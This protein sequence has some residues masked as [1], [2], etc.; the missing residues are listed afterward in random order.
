MREVNHRSKNMLAVVQAIARRTVATNPGEFI[1]RFGE[2]VRALAASQ[3][4]L[5]ESGWRG[6]DLHELVVSQ[7]S[8]LKDLVD[9]R[10]ELRGQPLQISASS[11]Q[12][13]GMAVHE[14][15]TNAVKYGALSNASGRI[16]VCWCLE[17]GGGAG[18]RFVMS[19]RESGGPVVAESPER[20]GFGST[21]LCQVARESLDAEVKLDFAPS[22]LV[23]RLECAAAEAIGTK[24]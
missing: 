5:I 12:V 2:R 17:P 15:A 8:H 18:E 4:L 24:D 20:R 3:D 14:L 11:A 10:I 6:V 22:G 7:L 19:W 13:I 9:S 1:E 21:V 23:W 16:D